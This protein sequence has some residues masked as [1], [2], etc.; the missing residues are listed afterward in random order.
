MSRKFARGAVALSVFTITAVALTGCGSGG[1]EGKPSELN[2]LLV[3][4]PST[5]GLADM[6]PAFEEETGIKVNVDMIPQSGMQAKY[7]TSLGTGA[8]QYDVVEAVSTNLTQL[9]VSQWIE[10]LNEHL[11]DRERTPEDYVEGYA[12]TMDALAID[13]KHYTV[14]FEVGADMLYYNKAMFV[15]AGLDPENPPHTMEEI[16]AAAE[17]LNKPEQG[18]AGFVARG[19]REGNENSFA[20]IMMWLLNGGRW[21]D[22]SGE[23]KFDILDTEAARTTTEQYVDLMTKYAPSGAVNYGYVEAQRAMQ[24]GQVAMWFDGAS[25]GPSLED[26]S[27][28]TIAG[29][30]GYSAPRGEG[31]NYIA[32]AVSGLSIVSGTDR[33]DEAWQLIQ[34][35]TKKESAIE[36][37]LTGTGGTPGRNDVLT[38]PAVAKLYNPQYVEALTEAAE[39]VNPEYSPVVTTGTEIRGAIS[40]AL[41]KALSG[42]ADA[43]DA[44]NA[45]NE[46]I[47]AILK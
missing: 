30:V 1:A 34:Y 7:N 13:G 37:A 5:L 43:E 29:N 40:V 46:E 15:E 19:T 35:L 36:L 23:Q 47:R 20:W 6:L 24:Q 11:E 4:S 2:M 38:D 27:V 28:S 14:P 44:M 26:P 21:E 39:H 3:E 25:L 9:T 41:S 16:L 45:A 17:K 31:G 32:G 12:A 33:A 22:K 8:N 42:Q 18:Q 10:P